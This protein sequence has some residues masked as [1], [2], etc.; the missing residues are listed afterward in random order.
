MYLLSKLYD[1]P[2]YHIE[3]QVCHWVTV[4]RVIGSAANL[5]WH[6]TWETLSI[7]LRLILE[8]AILITMP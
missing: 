1:S 5:N 2:S 6:D 3:P 8:L 4:P 7:F